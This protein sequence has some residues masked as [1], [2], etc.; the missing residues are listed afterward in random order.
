M[1]TNTTIEWADHTW[2]PWTGCTR[3]GPGCDNCYALA[4]MNQLNPAWPGRPPR[5]TANRTFDAPLARNR[6]GRYKWPDGD[7]VFACSWSDWFH[8]DADAWRSAAWD[9]IALRARLWFLL[10]TKRPRRIEGHLPAGW[11]QD[12]ERQGRGWANVAIGVTCEDQAAC[13]RAAT[14]AHVP[15]RLRFLSCEPLLGP[16]RPEA[17]ALTPSAEHYNALAGGRYPPGHR[18]PSVPE[19]QSRNAWAPVQWVI[20]GGETGPRARPTHVDWARHLRDACH[21]HAT[22]F[23]WKAWGEWI[24]ESQIGRHNPAAWLGL[25]GHWYRPREGVAKGRWHRLPI[26]VW[27]D[28]TRSVRLG[29]RRTGR[30]L[31]G[32]LLLDKP[33]ALHRPPGEPA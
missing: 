5:R 20:A 17:I 24:P 2:N 7:C 6:Q 11:W 21:R 3:V 15:C 4:R 26:H 18:G 30:R 10:L 13:H 16:V 8:A 25:D 23:F 19:L 1:T 22:A 33:A 9:R 29:R 32:E 12:D 27:P 14:L 28:G 31:D